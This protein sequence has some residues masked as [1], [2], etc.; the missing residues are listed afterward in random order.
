MKTPLQQLT[1]LIQASNPELMTLGV[2]CEMKCKGIN[3]LT[4]TC[5]AIKKEL[6]RFVDQK[7]TAYAWYKIDLKESFEIKSFEI[8]GK[9]PT[10]VDVLKW[11]KTLSINQEKEVF[12][13]LYAWNLNSIYLR[14]QSPELINFL[15]NLNK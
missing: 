4:L 15:I 3:E 10:L 5:F 12:S 8:I 2:G 14:D 7:A 13:L 11:M 6:Y 9:P 1:T